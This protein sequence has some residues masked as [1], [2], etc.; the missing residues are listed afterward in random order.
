MKYLLKILLIPFFLFFINT[1]SSYAASC[2]KPP[3]TYRN[4]VM[5]GGALVG[6]FAGPVV[7]SA[8]VLHSINTSA[9]AWSAQ[10]LLYNSPFWGSGIYLI[11]KG[12]KCKKQ[13]KNMSVKEL[14]E[15][16]LE[17]KQIKKKR[18]EQPHKKSEWIQG[19]FNFYLTGSSLQSVSFDGKNSSD[20]FEERRGSAFLFDFLFKG[21]HAITLD[22]YSLSEKKKDV[23]DMDS[24]SLVSMG[25]RYHFPFGFYLGAGIPIRLSA[26]VTLNTEQK[27]VDF[28]SYNYISATLP[29]TFGY[30]RVF[31]SGFTLGAHALYMPSLPSLKRIVSRD[32]GDL[33]NLS[34]QS[35][36]I[37]LGYSW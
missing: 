19:S 29:I 28:R 12:L 14:E 26:Q 25:Y 27:L 30:S 16:K 18:K 7:V 9:L 33:K 17:A 20:N 4:Y 3:K 36:G 11:D 24:Y 35:A 31:P 21:K 22:I 32:G 34:M 37:T 8:I 5:A 10:S 1:G 15:I 23:V 6:I 13:Q 2:K